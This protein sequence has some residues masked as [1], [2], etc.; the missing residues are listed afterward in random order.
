MENR[1]CSRQENFHALVGK[2]INFCVDAMMDFSWSVW[3]SAIVGGVSRSEFN[4]P[5]RAELGGI[6]FFG[7]LK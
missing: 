7:F 3:E 5:V 4:F 2:S 6:S 1:V